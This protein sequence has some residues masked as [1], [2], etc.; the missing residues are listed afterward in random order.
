MVRIAGI[1]VDPGADPENDVGE[2]RC[3]ASSK[4]AFI[5]L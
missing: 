5:N 3:L 2:D 4:P 1:E